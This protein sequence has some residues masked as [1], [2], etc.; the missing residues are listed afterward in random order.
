MTDN[1]AYKFDTKT[2]EFKKFSLVSP[3]G[4]ATAK[5]LQTIRLLIAREEDKY[6]FTKAWRFENGSYEFHLSFDA[7]SNTVSFAWRH[8]VE[9]ESLQ[10][11]KVR[12][13]YSVDV[14][15]YSLPAIFDEHNVK[16]QRS[17][18]RLIRKTNPFAPIAKKT[19]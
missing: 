8:I 12:K 14:C 6:Y 19:W 1:I 17:L 5:Y 2:A 4:E 7:M 3:Q 15:P 9:G 11:S 16:N 13:C 10:L 18:V